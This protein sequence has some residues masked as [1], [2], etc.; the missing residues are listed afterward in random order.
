MNA[1]LFA[2]ATNGACDCAAFCCLAQLGFVPAAGL[3]GVLD[4]NASLPVM[5][6]VDILT[7]VST[8]RPHLPMSGRM[9]SRFAL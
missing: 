9:N 2:T 8:P 1:Y 4:R 5:Q 3:L 6:K 7:Q